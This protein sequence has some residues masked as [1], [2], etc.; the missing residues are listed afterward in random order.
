MLGVFRETLRKS[1]STG[2]AG[3]S[4]EELWE[5]LIPLGMEVQAS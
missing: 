4:K 3:I 5:V 2:E 1:I